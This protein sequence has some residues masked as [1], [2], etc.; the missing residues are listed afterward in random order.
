MTLFFCAW[1]RDDGPCS[2]VCDAADE[3]QARI[4][5]R[6]VA[7]GEAPKRVIKVEPGVFVAEVIER[8]IEVSEDDE[9]EILLSP[10]PHVADA[11][12]LLEEAADGQPRAVAIDAPQCEA[13]AT[14]DGGTTWRCILLEGHDGQ[15]RA[16]DG[17]TWSD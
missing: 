13:E 16:G 10:F 5:A 3:A 14:D 17:E 8:E 1:D 15:H 2:V 7:E 12:V 9:V 6:D 11:L 4:M